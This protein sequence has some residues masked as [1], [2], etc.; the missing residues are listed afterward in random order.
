MRRKAP[1]TS[2][3]IGYVA[4]ILQFS[5]VKETPTYDELLAEVALLG[6]QNRRKDER[7]AYLE[8]LLYGE[9]ADRL[10]SKVPDN[11]PGL[12]DELFDQAMDEKAA[13]V[14]QMTKEI[15]KEASKRRA[16]AKKSPSRPS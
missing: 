16:A 11:Q 1:K 15:E 2:E 14:K 4:N 6:E 8:C 13:Q 7:I 3:K 9:K 12:F 5:G 10:A